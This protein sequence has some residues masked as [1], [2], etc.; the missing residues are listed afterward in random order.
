M[1]GPARPGLSGPPGQTARR[2]VTVGRGPESGTAGRAETTGS[3][4]GRTVS[5]R[6]AMLRAVQHG[7]S[8]AAGHSAAG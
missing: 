5:R 6:L 2:H 1:R 7:Q 3:V 4:P 8:G